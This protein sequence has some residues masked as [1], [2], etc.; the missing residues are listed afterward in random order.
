MRAPRSYRAVIG[1]GA[2]IGDR[3]AT[4]AGARARLA[5]AG[6]VMLLATSSIYETPAMGPPQPDYLNAALLVRTR[7]RARPLLELC[8]RIEAEFGRVRR[9]RWGPRTLDLDLLWLSCGR[10]DL[11][12]LKVPHPGLKERPFALAPLLEVHPR[13]AR[14]YGARLA[15]LGAPPARRQP[16]FPSWSAAVTPEQTEPPQRGGRRPDIALYAG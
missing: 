11:P 5:G 13:L 14:A 2:N 15:S 3:H 1:M 4:L 8:L 7:L 9:E 6:D 10:V 12:N 16:P